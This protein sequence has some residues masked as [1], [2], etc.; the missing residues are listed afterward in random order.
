M[1]FPQEKLADLKYNISQWALSFGF[2]DHGYTH[3]DLSDQQ[4]PLENWLKQGYQADMQWIEDGKSMRLNPSELHPNTCSIIAFKMDYLPEDPRI[5]QTLKAPDTAYVSRYALGRDYHK[6]VRKRLANLAKNIQV[7]CEQNAPGFTASLRP[8]VDSAPVLERPL[9]EKAGLGWTGKHTLILNKQAGSWFFLGELFTNIPFEQNTKQHTNSCGD[10]TA[11]L[12][13]C[14]TDAFPKPYVLDARRCISYLTI[15]NKGSI[16]EPFREPIGNRVFGCDDCQ[17]ICPWNKYAKPTNE[18]DFTPRH[19]LD[20]AQLVDLFNWDET[21]FLSNTQGSPIRRIGFENW[22]RNLAVGLGN[23][24]ASKE[25]M[26]ALSERR[27][28]SSERVK[29]H[30]DWALTKLAA[31]KANPTLTRKRKIKRGG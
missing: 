28:N 18:A 13:V 3:T 8:F 14:P 17:A 22:Q 24:S 12:K 23:G 5:I 6:L 10:C 11:C 1:I 15:E 2:S 4:A 19:N 29:E 27:D 30:I 31:R 21:T 9:A 16:P 7:W 20:N 25:A 26:R